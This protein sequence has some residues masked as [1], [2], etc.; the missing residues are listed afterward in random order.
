[1]FLIKTLAFLT[2]LILQIFETTSGQKWSQSGKPYGQSGG[3]NRAM[4]GRCEPITIPLCKGIAYNQTIFPNL[5]GNQNQEEA[6]LDVHQYY[7]LVKVSCSADIRFF[8]CAMYAPVCTIL[9]DPLPPCRELCLSARRGCEDLMKQFGFPWPAGFECNK[10]PP[11]KS[12]LCVGDNNNGKIS[13]EDLEK[14]VTLQPD[15]P[16][17]PKN[18][19]EMQ[20]FVCP[21]QLQVPPDHE[22]K[23]SI[24]RT[25]KIVNV[26][27]CGAP[28]YRLFFS[29]DDINQMQLW[30]GILSIPCLVS[31]LF[32][33]ITFCI[34]TSRFPYPEK[35]IVYLS[36]CYFIVAIVYIVGWIFDDSIACNDAFP[37]KA[38]NLE[39][40]RVL[41]QGVL[42]DWRCSVVGMILYFFVMAGAGWWLALTVAWFLSAGLKW[43]M[44]AI[45]VYATYFH[46]IVW[47]L[48]S[49]QTIIVLILKKIEGDILSGVCFVGI[50]QTDSLLYLIIIPLAFYLILGFVFLV[51]GFVCLIEVCRIMKKDGNKTNQLEAYI[52]RIALFSI[53]YLISASVVLGCYIYE[54]IHLPD[55]MQNWQ[56]TICRDKALIEKWQVPCRYP[57]NG[58]NKEYDPKFYVFMLKY[59]MI[60]GIGIFSGVW[61]WSS[62]VKT[63]STWRH[64]CQRYCGSP[65][66]YRQATV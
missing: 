44:E 52:L 25:P 27:N 54:Y 15:V 38:N 65:A 26:T 64:C 33:I 59:G 7:P 57:D 6:G 66:S 32:T 43:S 1:M 28:C 24:G 61:V 18:Y 35:P 34:D 3:V 14:Y 8:L 29:G 42:H 51:L 9:E 22:Y 20:D 12:E 50:L 19:D 16:S 4:H 48:A 40:E 10:F 56:E 60:N 58:Y 49:L 63:I 30:V 55:W 36:M 39:M 11:A 62:M 17:R 13:Q 45:D 37:E 23:L 53:L 5:M 41:K 46:G 47:A 21:A 31:T 2:L